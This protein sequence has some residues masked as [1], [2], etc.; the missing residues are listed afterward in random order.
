MY[1]FQ[2]N[3]RAAKLEDF[4]QQYLRAQV[5]AQIKEQNLKEHQRRIDEAYQ[6]RLSV[7]APGDYSFFI[8]H[9]FSCSG[10]FM[11]LQWDC[12]RLVKAENRE[13]AKKWKAMCDHRRD[14]LIRIMAQ[15]SENWVAEDRIDEVNRFGA[16]EPSLVLLP[17]ICE[18]TRGLIS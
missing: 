2:H 11:C 1:E 4:R 15:E 9:T 12:R 5:K 7:R 17:S 10:M 3:Y 18:T 16:C 8:R 6:K 13:E 14:E